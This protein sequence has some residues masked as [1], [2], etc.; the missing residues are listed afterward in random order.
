M[1]LSRRVHSLSIQ[2]IGRIAHVLA[3][4]LW[5]MPTLVTRMLTR[6]RLL[7]RM[8]LRGSRNLHLGRGTLRL[9]LLLLLLLL[10][11]ILALV[12]R[13]R[14]GRR[15]ITRECLLVMLLTRLEQIVG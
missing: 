3:L 10:L 15:G 7:Q 1:T 4:H 14:D 8:G 13:R 2:S 9:M 12:W 6:R 11:L 5:G